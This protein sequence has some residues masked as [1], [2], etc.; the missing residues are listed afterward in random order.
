MICSLLGGVW[1]VLTLSSGS[2]LQ[3]KGG[4]SWLCVIAL[5]YLTEYRYWDLGVTATAEQ[6]IGSVWQKMQTTTPFIMV[7]VAQSGSFGDLKQSLSLI[8]LRVEIRR[9]ATDKNVCYCA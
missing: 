7:Q 5:N 4:G 9:G 2:V 8:N 3:Y 6:R 1:Y